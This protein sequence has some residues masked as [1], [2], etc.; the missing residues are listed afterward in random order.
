MEPHIIER[1]I[2]RIANAVVLRLSARP[3]TLFAAEVED[4]AL[5]EAAACVGL[6][7]TVLDQLETKKIREIPALVCYY[8]AIVETLLQ[9]VA[10]PAV[11]NDTFWARMNRE[12]SRAATAPA[13]VD[14]RPMTAVEFVAHLRPPGGWTKSPFVGQLD[15][16]IALANPQATAAIELAGDAVAKAMLSRIPTGGGRWWDPRTLTSSMNDNSGD[17]NGEHSSASGMLQDAGDAVGTLRAAPPHYP[18]TLAEAALV[19]QEAAR[20]R[21]SKLASETDAPPAPVPGIIPTRM[22]SAFESGVSNA[23]AAS[24]H[25]KMK[26][27]QAAQDAAAAGYGDPDTAL[28]D[29]RAVT[30]PAPPLP[31]FDSAAAGGRAA[32]TLIVEPEAVINWVEAA[33]GPAAVRLTPT[34]AAAQS[35][36]QTAGAAG[37]HAAVPADVLRQARDDWAELRQLYCVTA[38]ELASRQP[39]AAVASGQV[40]AAPPAVGARTTAL[41]ISQVLS[42]SS[43]SG[44]AGGS[45]GDGG[46]LALGGS[47]YS[48]LVSPKIGKGKGRSAKGQAGS[49]KTG[50]LGASPSAARKPPA[51]TAATA[52]PPASASAGAGGAATAQGA[53]LKLKLRASQAAPAHQSSAAAAVPASQPAL[54]PTGAPSLKLKLNRSSAHSGVPAANAAVAAPAPPAPSAW[55]HGVGQRAPAL[56]PLL[57]EY[58]PTD[59][60]GGGEQQQGPHHET[61]LPE[62]AAVM[63]DD[64]GADAA[65]DELLEGIGGSDAVDALLYGTAGSGGVQ[66]PEAGAAAIVEGMRD[67]QAAYS[68]L[69]GDEDDWVMGGAAAPAAPLAIDDLDENP[70]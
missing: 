51:P 6:E 16:P 37:S 39:K 2:F 27:V 46:G 56:L 69:G 59:E 50:P 7:P 47:H 29:V 20:L 36:P 21:A 11:A 4:V 42:G 48:G 67:T 5:V 65:L 32:N 9:Q 52:A 3:A 12:V 66:Q 35:W 62:A 49:A 28:S 8:H 40:V 64:E 26:A 10:D 23:A 18:Q 30:P 58:E 61:R 24:A 13:G 70:L 38:L 60:D 25:R 55:M 15:A 41:G 43:T 57:D 31:S 54:A 44:M 22:I 34:L 45:G 68:L 19:M 17:T 53:S 1:T 63:M 14:L 33:L